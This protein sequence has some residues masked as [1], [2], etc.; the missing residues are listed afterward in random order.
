MTWEVLLPQEPWL[1]GK[2]SQHGHG[3]VREVADITQP[4]QDG[5]RMSG[6][7]EPGVPRV[8]AAMGM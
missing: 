2:P 7:R 8:T 1:P 3:D 5:V 4:I 6:G